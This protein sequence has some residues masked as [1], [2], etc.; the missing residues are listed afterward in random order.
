MNLRGT[1]YDLRIR[2][3][4]VISYFFTISLMIAWIPSFSQAPPGYYDPAT[5]LT[6]QAL[7]QALHNIIDDHTVLDYGS[8]YVHFQSTDAKPGSVVWDMYSDVPGG[9]P[10]YI[11]HYNSGD[12]CGNYSGEGDCYNR[13]HS[14][15]NSWFGG[16]VYPMYSDLFHL[17]PTDGYVNNRRGN[18]PYGTVGSATWT[19]QNGS[20]VGV[21]NAS[22]YSGNVFEPIDEY[23]GDFARS[24]FY[25]AV[26][27]YNEDQGWP[28]SPMTN[29]SQLYPWALALLKQWHTDDPVSSK[30]TSRNN[31]VYA[32]QENRNPFIDYPDFVFDLW[33]YPAGIT[34]GANPAKIHVIPNPVH[35]KCSIIGKDIQFFRDRVVKIINVMGEVTEIPAVFEND[36]V[37]LDPG[38]LE[39]GLYLIILQGKDGSFVSV[40]IIK[41]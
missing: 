4:R 5:G 37:R 6:G 29:G 28:G 33:G 21:C 25:M 11:Y 8:L 14:W 10:P 1:I 20:K 40:R 30:E 38:S 13:E 3:G 23:K 34:S 26:R 19:S 22:G 9:T 24:Y 36:A 17:Y 41:E 27:Y 16:T 31:A 15:P 35:D 7:Q 18:L 2:G 32:V 12:E 39:N